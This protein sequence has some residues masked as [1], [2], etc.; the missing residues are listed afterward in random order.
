MF[1]DY[2]A[3]GDGYYQIYAND[4][5][6]ILDQSGVFKNLTSTTFVVGD[7]KT[8]SPTVSPAPSISFPPSVPMFPVTIVCQLDQW[9]SETGFSI[10]ETESGVTF[11]ERPAGILSNIPFDLVVEAVRLPR[12]MEVTFTI[13]DTENDGFCCLYGE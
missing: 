5:S 4:G 7:P 9:S 6:L 10:E 1:P 12:D 13:T 2:F 8:L 3:T 11:F